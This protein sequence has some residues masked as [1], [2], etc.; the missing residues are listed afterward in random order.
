MQRRGCIVGGGMGGVEGRA[1]QVR[2]KGYGARGRCRPWR[3]AYASGTCTSA[4]T[5]PSW[6]FWAALYIGVVP[7]FM[8]RLGSAFACRSQET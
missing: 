7:L 4:T 8:A 5:V 1:Y 2:D 6:P 3:M